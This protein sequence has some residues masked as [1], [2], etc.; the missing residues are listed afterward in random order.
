MFWGYIR[1]IHF[2]DELVAGDLKFVFRDF[3]A[4]AHGPKVGEGEAHAKSRVG[5]RFGLQPS[6]EEHEDETAQEDEGDEDA[7]PKKEVGP[8]ILGLGGSTLHVGEKEN[9]E[10]MKH[11]T[12]VYRAK[13]EGGRGEISMCSAAVKLPPL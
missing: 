3:V 8:G 13:A 12:T 5:I 7:A 9:R 11:R 6:A 1:R 2:C 10:K 4:I